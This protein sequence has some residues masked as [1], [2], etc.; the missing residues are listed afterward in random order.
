MIIKTL[1]ENTAVLPDYI[2]EHGLSL[3]IETKKHKILFDLG[4]NGAF[5]ENAKKLNVNISDVDIVVISHGHSDHGGGLKLLLQKNQKA[6]VYLQP[7]AFEKHYSNRPN[8]KQEFIGLD[9]KIRKSNRIIYTTDRFFI[10]TGIELFSNIKE[11][12][13]LSLSNR[14]LLMDRGDERVWDTFEHE[15]NLIITENG[16]TVLFAGCAHNGIVNIVNQL[17]DMKKTPA[18]YVFGGFHLYSNSSK[19]SEDPAL[20]TQIAE[21][22][23]NTH[24]QY[25]TCHCTGVEPYDLLKNVMGDQIQYLATGSVV[26]I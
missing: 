9:Q 1:V 26:E 8:G 22:L 19:K 24:S 14:V 20:V 17:M 21:Y 10:D 2:T 5:F 11:N 12:K 4:E 25:Y 3:Y 15:Q 23:K 18:D 6:S 13:M 16:K 7:K